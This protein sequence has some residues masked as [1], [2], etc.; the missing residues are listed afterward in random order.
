MD[1]RRTELVTSTL[2]FLYPGQGSQRV[3]MGGELLK[4][5]PDL[6]E[7]YLGRADAVAQLPISE[8]CRQGPEDALMQ[9]QVAQ[10]ALF[11]L[12]SAL[13][14]VAIEQGLRPAFVAGHSLG[15][16]TAAVASGALD[17][18]SGLRLVA[19]R[20]RLMAQIQAE[21]PGVM[22]AVIGLSVE[23][24]KELCEQASQVGL[25]EL[26]N[27]NTRTQIVVSGETSGISALIDL[28][29]AAGAEKAVRLQVGAAF[30]SS[31]MQPVQRKLSEFMDTLTWRDAAVPLVSNAS[32]QLV[33]RSAD[34]KQALVLQIARPV[35]WVECV[36]TLR[37]AG[38]SA[39]LELGPGRVLVGLTR[40]IDPEVEASA[41]DSPQ[42]VIS[43]AQAR[44]MPLTS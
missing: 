12:S 31:L 41:A 20:G 33:T 42:K 14:E 37:Q 15:E 32:G 44:A 10:P 38:C 17:A 6:F 16:Y 9:T 34:V 22:A 24:L 27:L 19:E 7:K 40:Q 36:T 21:S 5:R 25:V 3:G 23:R 39:V 29:K 13:T 26:A 43:F 11:A 1:G 4:T 8:Y 35:R 18:E 30:H 28:A 2:A